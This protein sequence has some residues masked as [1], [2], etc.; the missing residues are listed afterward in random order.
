AVARVGEGAAA[1]GDVVAHLD[2]DRGRVGAVGAGLAGVVGEGVC[3]VGAADLELLDVDVR[4]HL[5]VVG[6]VRATHL[7]HRAVLV[8]VAQLLPGRGSIAGDHRQPPLVGYAGHHQRI[9]G[10]GLGV[11]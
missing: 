11:D 9:G 8:P 4:R 7:D 10:A 6:Q 3:G 5:L 1:H 2:V